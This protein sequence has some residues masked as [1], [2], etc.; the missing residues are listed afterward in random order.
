[1]DKTAKD[2]TL[3]ARNTEEFKKWLDQQHGIEYAT[4]EVIY[5]MDDAI[6]EDLDGDGR[7]WTVYPSLEDDSV[8]NEIIIGENGWNTHPD[9]RINAVGYKL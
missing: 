3:Y 4:D 8:L 2:K 6:A 5:C 7:T 1:M 9:K